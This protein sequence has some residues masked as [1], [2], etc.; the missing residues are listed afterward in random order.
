MVIGLQCKYEVKEANNKV[1][2]AEK[3]VQSLSI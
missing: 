3:V 2:E 1:L